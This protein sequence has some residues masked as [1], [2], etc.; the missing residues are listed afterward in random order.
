[1]GLTVGCLAGFYHHC[2]TT[3]SMH[4]HAYRYPLY[5]SGTKAGLCMIALC[6]KDLEV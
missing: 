3:M 1:M 4:M 5:E 6:R 2:V